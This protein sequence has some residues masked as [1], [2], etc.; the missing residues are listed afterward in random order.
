MYVYLSVYV[1]ICLFVF[2]RL[3]FHLV[4]AFSKN[5][6]L[7]KRNLKIDPS[8]IRSWNLNPQPSGHQFPYITTRQRLTFLL[9]SAF[10]AFHVR[11]LGDLSFC[12]FVNLSV[13]S[14]QSNPT[15]VYLS[16]CFASPS[17]VPIAWL[18]ILSLK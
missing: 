6:I 10:L 18:S 11:L 9:M 15:F 1:H 2:R 14:C 12:C 3:L 8:N 7:Q 13:F 17:N 4:L 16:A 5:T